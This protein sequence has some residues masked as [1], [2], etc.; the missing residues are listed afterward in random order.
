MISKRKIKSFI[1]FNWYW[2]LLILFVSAFVFY[3]LFDVI[4]SPSYEQTI[5]IFIGVDNLKKEKMSENLS[6]EYKNDNIKKISIDY[7]SPAN[8]NFAI[9]FNTRGLVNTD[10]IIMPNSYLENINYSSYFAILTE[11]ITSNYLKDDIDYITSNQKIYGFNITNFMNNYCTVEENYYLFLNK[12]SN[13]IGSLSEKDGTTEVLD[14]LKCF[15][16]EESSND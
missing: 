13:K 2:Y 14:L 16:K 3:S 7:S 11:N 10:I 5:S 15:L 9:I 4:N 12:K 8:Y 6:N 1:S